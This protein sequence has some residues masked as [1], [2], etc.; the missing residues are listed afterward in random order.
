M[1]TE[2]TEARLLAEWLATP[3][4]TPPPEGLSLEAV[5]AVYALRPDR[6]PGPRVTIDDVFSAVKVGPFAGASTA[7]EAPAPGGAPEAAVGAAPVDGVAAEPTLPAASPPSAAAPAPAAGPQLEQAAS[8][9]ATIAEMGDVAAE[10]PA[11]AEA[12]RGTEKVDFAGADAAPKLSAESGATGATGGKGGYGGGGEAD[13]LASGQAVANEP[14]PPP[15]ATGPARTTTATSATE[16]KAAAAPAE[17]AEGTGGGF[18]WDW[19]RKQESSST[20]AK[21]APQAKP[22]QSPVPA[23]PAPSGG[24]ASPKKAT[25]ARAEQSRDQEEPARERAS[26]DK[27]DDISRA[28]AAPS[29][30]RNDW[31]S[32]RADVAS[33][34]A[35]AESQRAAGQNDA[36]VATY[37]TL[38]GDRDPRVGQDVA[39]RA[40]RI[41][42]SQGRIA[43]AQA[44]VKRGLARSSANTVQ[45]SNLLVLDGDLYAAQGDSAA[46]AASWAEAERLNAQR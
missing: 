17:E 7:V 46:A 31:Y 36:A 2:E 34:Y 21:A 25:S 24:A 18:G 40:A 13:A 12:R 37:L 9:P 1:T 4:G 14:A 8:R 5:Q 38:L 41:L 44:L 42:E 26:A 15:P 39:W 35:T 19:G 45:R 6:A 20:K 32:G 27:D 33:V 28:D 30:Y 11:D 43:D 22:A 16:N 3:A 10:D 23:A 29:D